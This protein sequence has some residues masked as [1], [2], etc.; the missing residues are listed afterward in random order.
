MI[1]PARAADAARLAEIHVAAWRRG[2]RGILPAELLLGVSVERRS[3]D[4][5]QWLASPGSCTFVAEHEGR[6]VGFASIGSLRANGR[7]VRSLLELRRLYVDP[8]HWRAGIG[9]RLHERVLSEARARGF[10][11]LVLWVLTQNRRARAFYAA[12]GFEPDRARRVTIGGHPVD[13]ARYCLAVCRGHAT[14]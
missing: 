7:P 5:T 10:T 4:W 12:L 14:P 13:E 6:P 3:R 2:C 1:R 9:R 11:Q 8:G